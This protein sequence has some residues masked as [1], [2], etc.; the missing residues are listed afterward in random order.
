MT[1]SAETTSPDT[2]SSMPAWMSE[3]HIDPSWIRQKLTGFERV[4]E[5][6]VEDIS[7]DTRKGDVPSNGATLLLRLA[8]EGEGDAEATTLVAKQVPPSGLALSRRL[9]LAREAIFYDRL[10]PKI[11]L[12]S[13]STSSPST[14]DTSDEACI[15]KIY[16]SHGDMISGSKV[17]VMEDLSKGYIDSGILFGPGNPNNWKRDLKLRTDEAYP[18]GAPTSFEVADR[19]FSAIASVHAAFWRDEGLLEEGSEWLRGAGWVRGEDEAS[20]R[21]SMSII[22]TAWEKYTSNGEA[23]ESEVIR[24]D[25]LVRQIVEKAMRGI[26]WE[27]QRERLNANSHFCLV[28]G[29][30]WPGNVMISTDHK[31]DARNADERDL[32]LLDWEMVGES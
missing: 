29:D 24:W 6:A 19:T 13:S 8:S 2:A 5:C 18:G 12:S 25:P 16:Y 14:S 20:W 22:Q 31:A 28:H 9:G 4:A 1:E 26:S 17:V 15:P 3:S 30:F 32:R 7:N 27:S 11:K 23:G 10:A 21:A